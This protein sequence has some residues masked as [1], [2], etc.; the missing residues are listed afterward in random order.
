M[1][2]IRNSLIP[3]GGFGA[4][5]LFGIIFAKKDMKIDPV[6]ENHEAIHTRQ[7]RELGYVFFY[8]IYVFEWIWRLLLPGNAYRNL[9]FEREAYDHQSDLSY[10]SHRPLFAQWKKLKKY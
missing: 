1:K 4:V 5:N 7:M 8:L 6:V 10:L 3:F 9:S 2:I